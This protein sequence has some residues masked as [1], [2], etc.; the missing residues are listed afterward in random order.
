MRFYVVEFEV[1]VKLEVVLKVMLFESEMFE[2][3]LY[4]ALLKADVELSVKLSK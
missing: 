3:K 4:V 1:S 2:V